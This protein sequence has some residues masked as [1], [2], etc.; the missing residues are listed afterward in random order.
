MKIKGTKLLGRVTPSGI[1]CCVLK[2]WEDGML[3]RE[4]DCIVG[5]E[6]KPVFCFEIQAGM[7]EF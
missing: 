1:W 5:K 3:E 6:S 7:F 4:E 2:K